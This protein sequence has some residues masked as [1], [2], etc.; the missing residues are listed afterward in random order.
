[1][2]SLSQTTG[3][4]HIL[5]TGASSG[6]GRALALH[7]AAPGLLLSLSGRNEARLAETVQACEARGAVVASALIDVTDAPAMERW[8]SVRDEAQPVDVIVAAA[9]IGGADV[10]PTANGESAALAGAIFG[11]NTL[12][13]VNTVAPLLP[14]MVARKR[15]QVAVVGSI[16]GRLG[17]PQSPVYSA[18]KAA[19]HI[20][21]D[22]LRRLVAPHGVSIT[23]IVP[24]FVDTPMSQSLAMPR[25][26]CWS[27]KRAAARIARAIERRERRCI[28]PWPLRVATALAQI[29]PLPILDFF[30]TRA[31]KIVSP[32]RSKA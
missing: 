2:S 24:G 14:R 19:V 26:F 29:V 10:V 6:I 20:Y 11:V 23:T 32:G 30:L 16:A 4:R 12:G 9:G 25:P 31:N 27:A 8:L 13:V 3:L 28:F 1:M 5:I 15:G 17:L 18:S 21:A 7:Y 22:G